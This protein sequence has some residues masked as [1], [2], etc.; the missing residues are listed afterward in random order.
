MTCLRRSRKKTRS[1][2]PAAEPA[3]AQAA[4][5]TADD[6]NRM[7]CSL[8]VATINNQ[9]LDQADAVEPVAPLSSI[10]GNVNNLALRC[11][12]NG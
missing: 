1:Q 2:A 7:A 4:T 3:P 12:D 8:V 9:K 11:P 5:I 10:V 6:S